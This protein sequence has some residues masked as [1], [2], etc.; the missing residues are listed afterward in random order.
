M[1]PEPEVR[2]LRLGPRDHGLARQTFL[3]LATLFDEP[4]EPLSLPYVSE[5]LEHSRLLAYA[6]GVGDR[7]VG[8]LVAHVL[9]GTSRERA[10]AF[11]YDIAVDP[12]H[13]Q[14][15]IGRALVEALRAGAAEYGARTVFVAA[16]ADDAEALAFYRALGAHGSAA[17]L[18]EFDVGRTTGPGGRGA[19]GSGRMEP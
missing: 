19:A 3:L 10:E 6:A 12:H 13:R 18:F 17:T 1:T 4:R 16:D 2:V 9:P 15:G 11:L 5:L 7:P 8:G 14:R